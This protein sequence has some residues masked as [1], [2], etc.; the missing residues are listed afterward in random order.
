[1]LVAGA[2]GFVAA[3][4]R[5]VAV[6][7][8]APRKGTPGG[9]TGA[10]LVDSE[11][12]GRRGTGMCRARASEALFKA[13]ATRARVVSNVKV[14]IFRFS[15]SR[16]PCVIRPR[17]RRVRPGRCVCLGAAGRLAGWLVVFAAGAVFGDGFLAKLAT[18]VML[19]WSFICVGWR[20][21]VMLLTRMRELRVPRLYKKSTSSFSPVTT[22]IISP[23]SSK[24]A[25][26]RPPVAIRACG[27]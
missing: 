25:F 23:C 18:S 2:A 22:V 6:A 14:F 5:F 27:S 26:V 3:W 15:K 7:A 21:R 24:N 12:I 16:A 13:L 20:L 11:R 1:M 10:T 17:G 9:G 4:V 19:P 8:G